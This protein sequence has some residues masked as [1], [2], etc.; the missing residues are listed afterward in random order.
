VFTFGLSVPGPLAGIPFRIFAEGDP[1]T[2]TPLV[3][4]TFST[5][6]PGT[7]ITIPNAAC[8]NCNATG[9]GDTFL[10]LAPLGL[11]Q[12]TCLDWTALNFTAGRP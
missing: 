9:A 11:G 2:G 10:F 6:T 4:G 3:E 1:L 8:S 7:G 12:S 5:A